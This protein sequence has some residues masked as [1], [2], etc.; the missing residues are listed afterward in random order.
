MGRHLE[1]AAGTDPCPNDV[2]LLL[3]CR[4]TEDARLLKKD[5]P[6]ACTDCSKRWL[7]CVWVQSSDTGDTKPGLRSTQAPPFPYLSDP[8]GKGR[9]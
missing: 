2:A 5:A 1:G 7:E 9:K 3:P 6:K 4:I 8:G